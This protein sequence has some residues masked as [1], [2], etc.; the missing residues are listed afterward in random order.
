VP[1][2]R[3]L[4]RAL[5]PFAL[6]A[7]AR[8]VDAALGT[9]LHT[10]LDLPGFVPQALALVELRTALAHVALWVLA[11]AALWGM[12]AAERARR[13]GRVLATT[14][15]EESAS[16]APL[17]LRPALTLL[18][19]AALVLRPAYP[20]AFTL[21]VALT[22]DWG[23]AQDAAAL[24]A[25]VALRLP[26]LRVP[27]PRAGA[28]FFIAFL[29][30]ALLTPPWAREW[31][32]H[33]G[34]EPKYLRMGVSLG[35]FA[36]LDV[37]PVSDEE[38]LRPP[39]EPLEPRPLAPALGKAVAT[40]AAESVRMLEALTH[41]PEA[42]GVA[43]IRATHLAR[44]TVRGKQGGVF[45]I[46]APGPSLLLA[47]TLRVDRELNLAHGTP[48]RL[49]VTVLAWNALGAALVAALFLLLRDVTGRPGLSALLALGLA[50]TPPF[51][52][53]FFQFYPEMPGALLMLLALRLL[54][55]EKRWTARTALRLG[56]ILAFLPWLH[57]KFLPV[58]GVLVVM[59]ALEAVGQMVTLHA[60]LGLLIPQ[61]ATLFLFALYNFGITGS[62]RPDALFLAWGPGGVTSA[63]IGEGLLG[64]LLDARYGLLPAAPIYLLAAGGL[65]H[66]RLRWALPAVL[67]YYVTVASA[68]NW[69]GSVCNLGR[70]VMPA[71]P[72]L[73]ALVAVALDR[74]GPRRGVAAV[75]LTLAAW[76][77][78]LSARLW[79]DPRA[80]N[81]S[82]LLLDRSAFADADVYLPNLFFRSWNYA[83]PGQTARVFAWVALA[84]LLGAWLRRVA[85]G[86]GGAS[87]PRVLAGLAAATLV[88]AIGLERW[89]TRHRVPRFQ[90]A[91]ELEP[92]SVAFVSGAVIEDD[93][94]RA[95]RGDVE[96]LVRSREPLPAVM[97][98]ANGEGFVEL[99]GRP[100]LLVPR[101]GLRVEVP[102]DRIAELTGRRGARE[103]LSGKR[104]G[105][106]SKNGLDL[107]FER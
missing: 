58:W 90:D 34:N 47:P 9:L 59:A 105:I 87:A 21:P 23:I 75:A 70:Y 30:Y 94:V 64:L 7:L 89:P 20:Y 82:A 95:A 72:F 103:S 28:V 31:K 92:G 41:G 78:M 107:R 40:M 55:F 77:A 26:P 1:S 60:L 14:L 38:D 62:V 33:P 57:Q 85:R 32:G 73:A 63:R 71:V 65:S 97:L 88:V 79:F 66:R 53:Y 81:D 24:A 4:A 11:G 6:H 25:F 106:E 61:A 15:A 8:E 91:L 44:Q 104:L 39:M 100:R 50:V 56:L 22:Q 51:L 99:T 36:G 54:L 102:L 96:I 37:E 17:Y 98:V 12:L 52:F 48:G 13:E 69:S 5:L 86:R 42:V 27:A 84:A 43:A 83:A 10:T 49:A 74:S 18:A 93:H 29:G 19:L 101:S 80:A 67:A 35:W 68:D 3:S 76:T 46:L 16:F 45:H 2:T